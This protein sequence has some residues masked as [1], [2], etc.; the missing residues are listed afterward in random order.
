MQIFQT[1]RL[2]RLL[3]AGLLIT[4]AGCWNSD[5]SNVSLGDVSVGQQL[6]DLQAAYEAEALT[7]EEY[8]LARQKLLSLL[9]GC[10]CQSEDADTQAKD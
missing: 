8:E 1:S 4:S 5:V 2:S 10:D 6:L 3:L 9:D 7:D